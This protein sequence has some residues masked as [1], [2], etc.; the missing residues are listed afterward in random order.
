MADAFYALEKLADAL[1][2]LATGSGRVQGS[3]WA[4]RQSFLSAFVPRTFPT[5]TGR[6]GYACARA[7]RETTGS[8][9]T[10]AAK[11]RNCRRCSFMAIT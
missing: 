3:A 10:P 5:K 11:C 1:Y 8:A 4:T 6:D 9:A 2:A 7:I